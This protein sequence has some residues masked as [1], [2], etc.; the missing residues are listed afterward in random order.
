[1]KR[2]SEHFVTTPYFDLN[3]EFFLKPMIRL[4]TTNKTMTPFTAPP[5]NLYANQLY[6]SYHLGNDCNINRIQ[7]YKRVMASLP[8]GDSMTD[9][10]V[11]ASKLIA[12]ALKYSTRNQ[13]KR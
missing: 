6:G 10:S 7:I 9:S 12:L 3:I 13:G 4:A 8:I 1:M 11:T 2:I 5:K